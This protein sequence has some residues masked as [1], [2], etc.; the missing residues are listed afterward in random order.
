MSAQSGLRPRLLRLSILTAGLVLGQLLLFGPS[1]SGSK[2]LLP[3]DLLA[4]TYLPGTPEYRDVVRRDDTLTDLVMSCDPLRRFTASEVRAGR[5]PLWNP[6]IFAGAPFAN[7][8]KYSPFMVLYYLWPSP[9]TLAWM[10]LLKSVLAGLG[11]Y[12]FFRR[13]LGVRFWPAA[14][15]AWCYPLTGFFVFWQGYELSAVVAW[16]PWVLLCTDSV[17]RRPRGYGGPALA[18]ASALTTL[19]GV[20]DLAAQVLLASVFYAAWRLLDLYG[21]RVFSRPAVAAAAAAT[22]AWALGCCL[23]APYGLPLADY[24]RESPRIGNRAAGQEELEPAGL[25]ALPQIVLPRMYG[26]T[27]RGSMRV[28]EEILLVSSAVAYTGLLATLLVAPLAWC[29]RRHRSRNTF[30]VVSSVVALGW[31]LN[32]PGLV[33]V[34]RLPVLNIFSHYRWV[35]VVSFAILA[36][37]VTGLE[38]IWQAQARRQWWFAVPAVVAALLGSWCVYRSVYLPEPVATQIRIGVQTGHPIGPARDLASVER[39]QH[40]FQRTYVGGAGLCGLAVAGW[41]LLWS[42]IRLRPEV[43]FALGA[44]LVAELLWFA[45]DNSSQSDPRLYYPRIKVLEKVAQGPPGRTLGV[46]CLPPDFNM[47]HGIREIRGYDGVDP[48]YLIELLDL[49]RDKRYTRSPVYAATQWYV[50]LF[51]PTQA[52]HVRVPPVLDMLNVRYLIFRG[53][54]P[55]S[56]TPL[57]QD[58]G[59]WVLENSNVLPRA[60]VPRRVETVTDPAQTLRKL[61]ARDF[62][63]RQV[64]YVDQP[65]NIPGDGVGTAE[66]VEEIPSRVTVSADMQTSGL[67]VLAD[68]WDKGWRVYVNG[69]PAPL[70]RAN[71]AL[72]GVQVPAG[73][74][75]LVFSYEPASFTWSVRL[76]YT[77][78]AGVLFWVAAI[79]LAP[80]HGLRPETAQL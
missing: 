56:V 13:V 37:A 8:W 41:V 71:Y 32:I 30:W 50:P 20:S 14:I 55:A 2:I 6:Y 11:A 19:S 38:V 48:A 68:R 53:A 12:L 67:V 27:E 33:T 35:F 63:P 26:T 70:L 42:G 74:N 18:V 34:F 79:F 39:I 7:F 69:E 52:G 80:S 58:E 78:L 62:N 28:A 5:L 31:L 60:Y 75:R 45:Y 76:M 25:A 40:N 43:G 15:G 59:Y 24:L 66:I 21:R 44:L 46:S 16:Y 57:W 64:A 22:C 51:Q 72:R 77:G 73:R 61:A 29:S 65:V 36:M 1:L 23:A 54:A 49:A 4:G 3:L 47:T 17:I 9:V 10:Q